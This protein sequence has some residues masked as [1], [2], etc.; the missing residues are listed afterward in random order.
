MSPKNKKT[1]RLLSPLLIFLCLFILSLQP[2]LGS[3]AQEPDEKEEKGDKKSSET[4]YPE[5]LK[6][7]ETWET[8]IN[9]PGKILFIPF[10]LMDKA[11]APILSWVGVAPQV[12]SKIARLLVSA[13]GKRGLLPSTSDRTG[14]GLKFFQ[15]DLITPGSHLDLTVRAGISWRQ[16]CRLRLNRILCALHVPAHRTLLRNRK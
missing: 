4:E 13:D 12:T 14:F 1:T 6:S 7:E 5:K 15:K 3:S 16:F 9:I 10:W 2:A 8:L 11:L